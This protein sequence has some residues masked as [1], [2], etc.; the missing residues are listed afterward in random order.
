[1]GDKLFSR[2]ERHQG[3]EPWG[4]VLDAG[5][6]EHSMRWLAGLGASELV[7]VTAAHWMAERVRRG[8]ADVLRP[9]DRLVVGNWTDPTLLEGE[10]F[11]TVVA[12]YLL[13][14]IDGFAP[15]FQDQLFSRLLP[16]VGRRLYVV[17]MAPFPDDAADEGGRL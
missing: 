1:M 7:G 15:Y 6:G 17:G 12:D 4:A 13:G 10:R 5:A 14:A 8:L 11:D 3:D 16:H 2:I 9:Q